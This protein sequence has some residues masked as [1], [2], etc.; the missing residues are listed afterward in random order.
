MTERRGA[1]GGLPIRGFSIL[2]A[3][4]VLGGCGG[5]FPL[6]YPARTLGQG[7]VRAVAGFSSNIAVGNLSTALRNAANDAAAQSTQSSAPS[8][9]APGDIT[10]AEGA[11]VA[12]SLGTGLAPILGAR[13][14]VGAQV[15]AGLAYTGRSLRADIRRSFD[16]SETWALSVGVGGSGALYGRDE[17][18]PLPNVDLNRLHG[19]GAD[20]PVLLGYQSDGDLYML[21]AGAHAGWE[22]VDIDDV[23]SEPGSGELG[24]SAISL[25]ATRFWAG[26]LFGAAVG[27]RHIHVAMEIDASYASVTGDFNGAHA[28]VA[29]L[30]LT[31]GTAL[32]WQF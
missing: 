31:P 30:S 22:H 15:E 24:P 20:V 16:L 29:G 3:A 14:G 12:A 4:F 7:D 9:P 1:G 32:W 8:A 13:V 25:A 11:L 6:L 5:G 17:S 21:W 2:C 18:A 26:G 23:T 19:W 10:Y 27:F 28:H